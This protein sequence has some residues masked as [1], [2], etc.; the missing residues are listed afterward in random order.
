MEPNS[1]ATVVMTSYLKQLVLAVLA[2]CFGLLFANVSFAQLGGLGRDPRSTGQAEYHDITPAEYSRARARVDRAEA[3]EA[4][5][6]QALDAAVDLD[7]HKIAL[8]DVMAYLAEKYTVPIYLDN[9]GLAD[10]AVDS[11]VPITFAAH[12]TSLRAALRTMLDEFDLTFVIQDE[13]LKIT[14]EE[15]A[16]EILTTKVYPVS[17]LLGARHN[18]GPLM[19]MM[20]CTVQPDSWDDNGGPGSIQSFGPAQ[21]LVISQKRDVHEEIDELFV[22][23]RRVLDVYPQTLDVHP[24]RKMHARHVRSVVSG[25]SRVHISDRDG[26]LG[27]RM[28]FEQPDASPSSAVPPLDPSVAYTTNREGLQVV[29]GLYGANCRVRARSE[30]VRRSGPVGSY[31]PTGG[32]FGGLFSIPSAARRPRM[33]K[34]VRARGSVAEVIPRSLL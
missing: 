4:Y 19:N 15:K 11:S 14:S 24:P 3:L 6:E 9:K 7:L 30:G 26:G 16:D 34:T 12:G 22:R 23:L 5:L 2:T 13:V 21:A 25:V 17:D 31:Q 33:P 1:C 8:G 28:F 27:G 20:K 18:F 32:G 29:S 10:A